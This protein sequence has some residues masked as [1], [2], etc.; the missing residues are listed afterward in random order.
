MRC[1]LLRWPSQDMLKILRK[2]AEKK[3]TPEKEAVSNNRRAGAIFALACL[4]RTMGGQV[5][6]PM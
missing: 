1:A 2:K 3:K 6:A 4:K 5:G